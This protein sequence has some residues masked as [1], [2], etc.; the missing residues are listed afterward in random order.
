MSN[1]TFPSFKYLVTKTHFVVEVLSLLKLSMRINLCFVSLMKIFFIRIHST[2]LL[3]FF[4]TEIRNTIRVNI[5]RANLNFLFDCLINP[6][7]SYLRKIINKTKLREVARKNALRV[8]RPIW[9]T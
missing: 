8:R 5:E 1:E 9:K 2:C 6:G 7:S 3:F 4:K